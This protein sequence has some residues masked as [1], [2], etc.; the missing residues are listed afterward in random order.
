[1]EFEVNRAS[2]LF[3]TEKCGMEFTVA[4]NPRT[5]GFGSDLIDAGCERLADF[6]QVG[7][8]AGKINVYYIRSVNGN[9]GQRCLDGNSDVLLIGAAGNDSETLAHELGHALSLGHW[10]D[11][12]GF[13]GDNLMLSPGSNRD[14]ISIGQCFR[15]N[16]NVDSVFQ[17]SGI[18]KWASRTCPDAATNSSCPSLAVE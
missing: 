2:Q 4:V 17:R 1:V 11:T 5:T 13:A 7:E 12:Q 18:S 10:N 8:E 14:S 6:K 9:Q 15:A 16:I 3:D